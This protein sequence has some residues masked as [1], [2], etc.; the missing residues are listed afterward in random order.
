M[1]EDRVRE[2][3]LVLVPCQPVPEGLDR[4]AD[5]AGV[6]DPARLVHLLAGR[7]VDRLQR[8]QPL[9]VAGR[10]A[11]GAAIEQLVDHVLLR[12]ASREREA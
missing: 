2:L 9:R 1:L 12:T 4:P 11:V 10:A 7:V 6:H 8:L 3:R 5:V